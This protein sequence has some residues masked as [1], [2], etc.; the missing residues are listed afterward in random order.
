MAVKHSCFTQQI[1]SEPCPN[2]QSAQNVF[3]GHGTTRHCATCVINW[4]E[5]EVFLPDS[6]KA[7]VQEKVREL[8]DD[9]KRRIRETQRGL[10]EASGLDDRLRQLRAIP[11][12]EWNRAVDNG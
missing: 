1:Y 10:R 4:G 6:I 12:A 7:T 9:I 11:Q 5:G 2:C 3:I 8:P